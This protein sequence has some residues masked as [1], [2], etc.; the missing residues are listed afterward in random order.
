MNAA[1]LVRLVLG[2]LRQHRMSS[3][4]AVVGVAAGIA[5]LVAVTALREETHRQFTQVGLGVDAVLGPKGSPLQVVLNA[6]YHLEE[7]P[8]KIPWPYYDTVRHEPVVADGFPF[9]TGHSY[10]GFRV[11]AVEAR[12]LS[13]FSYLPERHFSVAASDGGQ[14]RFFSG[15]H[16]AVAGAEAARALGLTLDSTFN[17]VCGVSAGDPVHTHDT[18]RIVGILA[19]TGT[20]HDRAIYIPL[21]DFYTLEGHG[22]ATASMATDLQHREISGAYLQL[23]R[24]RGG[25][26]H[27]GVQEMQYAINQSSKAQLVVPA[28]V[29]PRLFAI[30]GWVDRVLSA[31]GVL[32]ALLAGAF[33]AAA[34][35][36]T[37]RERR[38]DL[39]LLRALGAGRGTL[40]VLMLAQAL[41][42][43]LAGALLG[44]LAGHLLAQFGCLQVQRETGMHLIAWRLTQADIWL[45]PGALVVGLI[46][47]LWPA[48]QAYR[49]P[50]VKSLQS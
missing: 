33:L 50:V 48:I 38:H 20:P 49:L 18:I 47:G 32:V 46:A 24:I 34:L 27:P 19:P 30:I 44:A 28:E 16:E 17:P 6:L 7:M 12:F 2:S 13:D 41:A 36:S 39:A 14:G 15:H 26:M 31:V 10:G 43:T 23:V 9:V 21:E 35:A 29:M 4:L 5:L 1:I 11:N 42:I 37:L 22:N 8:G 45:L 40:L 3:L 25:A